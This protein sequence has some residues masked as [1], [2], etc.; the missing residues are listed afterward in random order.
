MA[1]D[2]QNALFQQ[3]RAASGDSGAGELVTALMGGTP[4]HQ[5]QVLTQG[6]LMQQRLSEARLAQQK[7]IERASQQEARH[8][9]SSRQRGQGHGDFADLYDAYE[10]PE[11]IEKAIETRQR[12]GYQSDLWNRQNANNLTA[13]Q[14]NALL[15]IVD[16]KPSNTYEVRDGVGFNPQGNAAQNLDVTPVGRAHIGEFESLMREHN[17]QADRARAGIGADKAANWELKDTPDGMVR[18][19]KLT[20]EISQLM[21]NGKPV[22]KAAPNRTLPES[23]LNVALQGKGDLTPVKDSSGNVIGNEASP[24]GKLDP[25]LASKF[26][27]YKAKGLDDASAI[28]AIKAE[29]MAENTRA[30][31]TPSADMKG[32]LATALMGGTAPAKPANSKTVVKQVIKNGRKVNVYADGSGDYAD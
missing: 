4:M 31:N 14:R 21:M 25:L 20:G 2:I 11:Q 23:F 28:Q 18:A 27:E 29:E 30:A 26:T 22:S 19:N 9:I 6:A 8:R 16:E 24:T 5:Q 3:R 10:N 12:T 15:A 1:Y 7:E 32:E 13:E 17:A